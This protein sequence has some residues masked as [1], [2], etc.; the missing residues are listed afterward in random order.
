MR[1]NSKLI[2]KAKRMLQI[3]ETYV[4]DCTGLSPDVI[5]SYRDNPHLDDQFYWECVH[6][7]TDHEEVE[8]E[9]EIVDND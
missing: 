6:W 9:L 1:S 3:T 2:L 7:E 5:K 8:T 4:M